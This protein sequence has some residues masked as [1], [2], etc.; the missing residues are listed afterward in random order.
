MFRDRRLG[1]D[2]LHAFLN[3]LSVLLARDDLLFARLQP[4]ECLHLYAQANV[5][6]VQVLLPMIVA[7]I[8]QGIAESLVN[9][10]DPET[11]ALILISGT[12]ALALQR[13]VLPDA[14]RDIA[15]LGT[16][17]RDFYTRM[18]GMAPG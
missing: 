14:P 7:V 2:K 5:V 8:H 12:F 11:T 16:A 4:N 15:A 10:H 17:G 18:L 6:C 13:Q 9:V 1:S 3:Y